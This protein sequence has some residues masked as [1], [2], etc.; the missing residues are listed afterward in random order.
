MLGRILSSVYTTLVEQTAER[1]RRTAR[2]EDEQRGDKDSGGGVDDV[3]VEEAGV[4][5]SDS[6]YDEDSQPRLKVCFVVSPA[7]CVH[8]LLSKRDRCVE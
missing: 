6:G 5:D 3:A 8:K 4:E 1:A 7:E 2:Q